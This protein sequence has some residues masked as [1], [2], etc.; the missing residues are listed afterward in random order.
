MGVMCLGMLFD[1]IR[2]LELDNFRWCYLVLE[3]FFF[4]LICECSNGQSFSRAFRLLFS[5]KF[6]LHEFMFGWLMCPMWVVLN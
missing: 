5:D 6:L 2:M 1:W 4:F 3:L